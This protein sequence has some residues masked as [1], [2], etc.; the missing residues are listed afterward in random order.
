M[1]N[2]TGPEGQRRLWSSA[3]EPRSK[4]DWRAVSVP[5]HWQEDWYDKLPLPQFCAVAARQSLTTATGPAVTHSACLLLLLSSPQMQILHHL[6]SIFLRDILSQLHK[7][8]ES[9]RDSCSRAADLPCVQLCWISSPSSLWSSFF[10][11]SSYFS[12][13]VISRAGINRRS[14]AHHVCLPISYGLN[15]C[16]SQKGTGREIQ[17]E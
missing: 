13:P 8:N 2:S 7:T 10:F 1:E 14:S 4:R 11:P 15:F 6:H 9:Q 16:C 5:I 17:K 3:G 12:L